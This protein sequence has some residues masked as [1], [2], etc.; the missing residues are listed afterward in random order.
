MSD[1]WELYAVKYATLAERYRRDNFI[2]VDP[3]DDAPM[4]IDYFVWAAVGAEQTFIIDTGFDAGEAA[5]RG[6]T[7]LR[8]ATNALATVGVAAADVAD[9]II[10]HLHYDHIGGFAEFPNARFHLQ[11]SEMRYATGPYM[12]SA[13]MNHSFSPDHIAAMVHRVFE[14]RVAF[15]DGA[16]ELAPGLSVH[17]VGGHTMGLQ[18]VRV[19]TRRGWVVVASD[20]THFY[21]NMN[22]SAPFPII[23]NLGDMVRAYDT[24][25]ALADSEDHIVPGHD[26]LVLDRYPATDDR[27][28]GIAVRLDTAPRDAG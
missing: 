18:V 10:T 24:L 6:R 21:E 7:L 2:M 28:D 8:S 19:R 3:H 17:H 26:P 5:R 25:R 4:P 14:G 12:C 1:T 27:L 16:A 20:A 22:R 13:T 23:Y 11:E 9:V 15:H